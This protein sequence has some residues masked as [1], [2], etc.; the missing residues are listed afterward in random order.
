MSPAAIQIIAG[1]SAFASI[2]A[3]GLIA[4]VKPPDRVA[5]ARF[6]AISGRHPGPDNTVGQARGR[7][8]DRIEAWLDRVMGRSVLAGLWSRRRAK[9]VVAQLPEALELIVRTLHAGLGVE[10]G[11]RL[12]AEEMTGPVAGEFGRLATELEHGIALEAALDDLGRRAPAPEVQFFVAAVLVQR[13][14]GGNLGEVLEK[15]GTTIRRRS[16]IRDMLRVK[17]AEARLSALAII[18]LAPLLLAYLASTNWPYVEPLFAEARGRALLRNAMIW[19][20][21]GIIVLNWII[22]IRI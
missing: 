15:L 13:V 14:A 4:L 18:A 8:R 7:L 5:L 17:S 1:L 22:R 19:Q 3:I 9:Q 2:L 12:I 11:F 10:T 21:V 6:E 16:E 20:F